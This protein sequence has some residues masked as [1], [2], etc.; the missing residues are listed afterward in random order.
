MVAG[1][2][3]GKKFFDRA[4]VAV[5]FA[6]WLL[7]AISDRGG[8]DYEILAALFLL[9]AIK[10]LVDDAL[11]LNFAPG[12]FGAH[13]IQRPADAINQSRFFDAALVGL[14]F[15]K[16]LFFTGCCLFTIAIKFKATIIRSVKIFSKNCGAESFLFA[17]F[18]CLAI[19][20]ASNLTLGL[21]RVGCP[22]LA[23]QLAHGSVFAVFLG[24][25]AFHSFVIRYA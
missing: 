14:E 24:I 8:T 9:S 11:A 6:G 1:F 16:S 22:A 23:V 12:I 7:L 21:V 19:G 25:D 4:T 20:M 10:T 18:G 3:V 2:C 13:M 17:G 15:T 5:G